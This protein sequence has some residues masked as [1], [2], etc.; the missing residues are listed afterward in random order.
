MGFDDSSKEKL[1]TVDQVSLQH[2][3][4][5]EVAIQEAIEAR[6]ARPLNTRGKRVPKPVKS[7]EFLVASLPLLTKPNRRNTF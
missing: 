7:G 4:G 6:F 1:G 2:Q 5:H 3:M